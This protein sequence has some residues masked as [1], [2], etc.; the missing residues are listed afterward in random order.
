MSTRY[1]PL[2]DGHANTNAQHSNRHP[3]PII[4][5][6]RWHR[7][8]LEGER[9]GGAANGCTH[10]SSGQ[11]MPQKLSASPNESDTLV[12]MSKIELINISPVQMVEMAHL[13]HTRTVQLHG[14]PSNP[15]YR[16][17]RP[18]RQCRQLKI[19]PASVSQKRKEQNTYQ[20][21]YKPIHPLPT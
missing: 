21:L 17:H 13:E 12:T 9:V 5:L 4:Q 6:P 19:T 1:I 7:L 8:L 16:V 10:S 15:S 11:P 18:K 14:S 2:P 3:K 20:G